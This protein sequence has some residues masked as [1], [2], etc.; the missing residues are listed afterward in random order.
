MV[1]AKSKIF[2]AQVKYINQIENKI[3]VQI[4]NPQ[5]EVMGKIEKIYEYI[6]QSY[7]FSYQN[8]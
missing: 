8:S 5:K 1:F 3:H 4:I 7:E 2:Q 6:V